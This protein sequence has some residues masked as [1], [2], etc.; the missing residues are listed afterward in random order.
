MVTDDVTIAVD[1]Y[2]AGPRRVWVGNGSENAVAQQETLP[3]TQAAKCVLPDDLAG[4]ID[5]RAQAR[6]SAWI[7]NRREGRP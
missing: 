6:N 1:S 2:G 7:I 5:V 4:V 3:V